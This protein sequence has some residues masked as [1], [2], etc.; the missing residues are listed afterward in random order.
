ML[1]PRPDKGGTLGS[2]IRVG[3]NCW[4]FSIRDLAVILYDIEPTKAFRQITGEPDRDLRANPKMLR[5]L[6]QDVINR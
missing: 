2:K 1:P 6:L 3:V 5:E 4:D